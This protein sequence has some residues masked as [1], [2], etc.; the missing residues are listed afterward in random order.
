MTSRAVRRSISPPSATARTTMSRSVTIPMRRSLYATG[1]QPMSSARMRRAISGS[2]VSGPTQLTRFV[3]TFATFI[4]FLRRRHGFR[5]VFLAREL[6]R[7]AQ[8]RLHRRQHF[9]REGRELVVLP[10]GDLRLQQPERLLVRL[11]LLRE[12]GLVEAGARARM[13]QLQL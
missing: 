2:V 8:V 7:H 11:D 1:M 4:S 6:V 10:G 12:V 5:L 9:R 3:M 13:Q